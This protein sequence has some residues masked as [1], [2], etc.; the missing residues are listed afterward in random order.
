MR[1]FYTTV[2]YE[3]QTNLKEWGDKRISRTARVANTKVNLVDQANEICKLD[4]VEFN[5]QN[6]HLAHC[7]IVYSVD[8]E[9]PGLPTGK[10]LTYQGQPVKKRSFSDFRV[11]P[12]TEKYINLR[13]DCWSREVI[14]ASYKNFVGANVFLEHDQRKQYNK[15]RVIDAVLRNTGDSYYVDILVATERRHV[16]IIAG[17]ENGNYSAMSMGC[18]A[19]YAICTRCGNVSTNDSDACWCVKHIKGQQYRCAE[20]GK[21]RKHGELIGH[22][23]HPNGYGGVEFHEA[24]WVASPAAP[25]AVKH[26]DITWDKAVQRMGS[27]VIGRAFSR[28]STH[29]ASIRR[30][31]SDEEKKVRTVT[32]AIVEKIKR[33]VDQKVY[34]DLKSQI[35]DKLGKDTGPDTTTNIN[36]SIV[37]QANDLRPYIAKIGRESNNN[38]DFCYNASQLL[39]DKG[40]TIPA[41]ICRFAA[42]AGPIREGNNL[43]FLRACE[44]I[45]SRKPNNTEKNQLL[46]L[47]TLLEINNETE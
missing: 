16:D 19:D 29:V 39:K 30:S 41:Y 14:K 31:A 37:K 8:T 47:G 5:E 27:A 24:S 18:Y 22:I 15:G 20:T 12:E 4:S 25:G 45:L 13:G 2:K 1:K 6:Y 44:A 46:L 42:I 28:R 32:D 9:D 10:N 7:T 38:Y 26:A 17:L 3:K 40:L 35:D 43:P 23:S 33:D 34:D 21:L 36:D 11:T